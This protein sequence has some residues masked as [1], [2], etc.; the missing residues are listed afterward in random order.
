M[1]KR[2]PL[3]VLL[4]LG[5][6]LLFFCGLLLLILPLTGSRVKLAVGNKIGVVEVSGVIMDAKTTLNHLK[7]FRKNPA[8]KAVVVRINSPGGAVGPAQEIL[9]EIRRLR[10]EKKVV[11]S[12]GTVAASGGYYIA[13]GADVIMANPGTLTGSIGVIMNFTNIEQLT[14]KLGVE[15]FNLKAGRFKDAGSPTRPM[16][17]AERDYLQRLLDDVHE[18]FIL[19]VA[20]GRNML[21]HQVRDVADGRVFTGAMAKEL[22]LV[23]LLGNLPEAIELA[24][25]LAGLTGKIEPV[26]LPKERF[27]LFRLFLGDDP[28]ELLGRWLGP[29]A[30]VPA[31]LFTPGQ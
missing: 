28:E 22:G 13:T 20:R 31:Y 15:L 4:L 1:A 17:P 2:S 3:M 21:L 5:V 10:Q 19:D 18:Q 24:G 6:I 12:L 23:D 11:A 14:Q 9:A 16:T 7:K 26:Y 30:A 8:I 29:G 25:N 27:S